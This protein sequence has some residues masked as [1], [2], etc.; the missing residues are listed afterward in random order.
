VQVKYKGVLKIGVF[1]QYH[2]LFQKWY[3]VRP[4]LQ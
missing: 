4:Y 1:D 2:A 3:K